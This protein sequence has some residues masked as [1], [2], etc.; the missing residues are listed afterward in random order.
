[1]DFVEKYMYV[2]SA[3]VFT[4][5]M[6]ALERDGYKWMSGDTPTELIDQ[7]IDEMPT[8][9]QTTCIGRICFCDRDS[10]ERWGVAVTDAT[11]YLDGFR[12]LPEPEDLSVLYG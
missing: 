3:D 11:D 2:Q 4:E 5:L 8:I 7:Y 10:V 9:V 12:D 6:D 1:M